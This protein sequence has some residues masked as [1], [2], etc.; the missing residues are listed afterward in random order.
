MDIIIKNPITIFNK[1]EEINGVPIEIST[2]DSTLLVKENEGKVYKCDG[3]LYKI[4]VDESKF[5]LGGAK[6][7]LPYKWSATKGYGKFNIDY[8]ISGSNAYSSTNSFSQNNCTGFNIG[9]D[10]FGN[11]VSNTVAIIYSSKREATS[12]YN[13]TFTILGGTDASN[14]NLIQWFR[15]N[16]A[17]IE[18]GTYSS[19]IF[20]EILSPSGTLEV[21]ANGEV[22]VKSYEKVN[23]NVQLEE[24]D[25]TIEVEGEGVPTEYIDYYDGSVVIE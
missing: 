23:V 14:Q 19:F 13:L 22:D 24:Y 7:I 1:V 17:T 15:D 25:G 20:Q 4:V 2:L 8:N 3:K 21:T 9:Y 18:G 5:F 11:L 10:I 6:I 12:S 16:N